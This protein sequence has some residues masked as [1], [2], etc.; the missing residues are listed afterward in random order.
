MAVPF[1]A[2]SPAPDTGS[3]GAWVGIAR[4]AASSSRLLA[5]RR[6]EYFSLSTR[7]LLNRCSSPRMPFLW[8]INPYRGCEFGCKYCY[9]RY[10][11][12]FLELKEPAAFEEKIYSKEKAGKILRSELCQNPGG[13]IAIGTATDPYQPAERWFGTTRGI[14]ETLVEFRGLELSITTKSDLVTRDIGLLREIG[15]FNALQVNM[16]ITTLHAELAR[17][18]EPRAPRPDLRLDAVA[19]LARSAIPVAVF[20]MPVLPGITDA[21]EQLEAIAKAAALAGAR[22]FAASVLFLKPAAQRA[23]FPYLEEHFPELARRYRRL[24]CNRAYLRGEVSE[25]MERLARRLRQQYGLRGPQT[26]RPLTS[27]GLRNQL[28]LFH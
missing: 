24:Y 25:R 15:Q 1:L 3:G 13:A 2:T 6:V 21:P 22:Y 20:A 23:F 28:S 5:K 4:L 19:T 18:L 16:T 10:T 9:A 8:T 11:H 17:R 12:E 26:P 14:L 27:F 7:S